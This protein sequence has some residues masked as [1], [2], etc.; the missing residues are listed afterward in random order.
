MQN[1]N[2]HMYKIF[3]IKIKSSTQDRLRGALIQQS[4]ERASIQNQMSTG[5]G[6]EVTNLNAIKGVVSQ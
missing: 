1:D 3:I 5:G 2:K 4:F 6:D